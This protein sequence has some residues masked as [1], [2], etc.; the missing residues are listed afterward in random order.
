MLKACFFR[1]VSLIKYKKVFVG[2]Y[3]NNNCTCCKFA[4]KE[5]T[6]R[7]LAEIKKDLKESDG[8]DSIELIGGE[9]SLRD[10][11]DE[12][13]SFAREKNF[14]RIKLR[15][16]GRA[17]FDASEVIRAVENGIFLF[18][19]KLYGAHPLEH[20]VITQV[21]GSFAETVRGMGNIK[22]VTGIGGKPQSPYIA[23]RIPI[24]KENHQNLSDIIRFLV[25]LRPDRIIL[26]FEDV[27][28][29]M[30]QAVPFVKDA[31]DMGLANM[32]WTFTE[33]IPLCLMQG[34]EHHV[35]EVYV[36]NEGTSKNGNC[37]GCAYSP[38]CQGVLER[39]T[40]SNGFDDFRPVLASKPAG[41]GKHAD[42]IK[43][44]SD[45]KN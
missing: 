27:G 8:C 18:E 31:I 14:R 25:P 11:L 42:D 34:F 39:Y 24:A 40:E 41:A 3:C 33:N 29:S 45:G 37:K 6:R 30:R 32:I 43:A 2:S 23:M 10:D 17:F 12:I 35:S 36:A 26:S 19:I 21:E 44:L 13:V 4:N 20:D 22:N 15:T 5:R 1:A 16:N 7:S 9:P 28:L 38:A